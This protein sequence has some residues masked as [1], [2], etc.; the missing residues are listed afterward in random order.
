MKWRTK[1]VVVLTLVGVMGLVSARTA[2]G[3]DADT[4]YMGG[5]IVTMDDKK[6]TA[7][8]AAV[9]DG[10]FIAVGT[11]ADVEKAHNRPA[12]RVSDLAGKTML[13]GFVDARSHDISSLMV[14]HQVNVYAPPAGPGKCAASIVVELVAYRDAKKIPKGEIIRAYGYDGTVMPG[15]RLVN[16]DDLDATRTSS[17]WSRILSSPTSTR[18]WSGTRS[19]VGAGTTVT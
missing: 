18:C 7:E 5:D 16:R 1:L 12:T 8:A 2:R 11:R 10:K 17:T 19:V 14:A 9:K 4:I 13:P 3:Q 6:P 15:G